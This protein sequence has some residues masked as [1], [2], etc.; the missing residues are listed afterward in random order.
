MEALLLN[1]YNTA[2]MCKL[3]SS[4]CKAKKKDTGR[5]T[6]SFF[7]TPAFISTLLLGF[8]IINSNTSRLRETNDFFVIY[9]C[10]E[11]Y[12]TL[13]LCTLHHPD[14]LKEPSCYGDEHELSL[15]GTME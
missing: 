8:H 10:D 4:Q 14:P 6:F 9:F 11:I 12:E 3:I 5:V 15:R 13:T 7:S 1:S 2:S